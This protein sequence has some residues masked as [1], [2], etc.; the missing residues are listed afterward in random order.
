MIRKNL[1][2]WLRWGLVFHKVLHELKDQ[3]YVKRLGKDF[4][5]SVF[6]YI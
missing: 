2:I 1:T 5:N 3:I 4:V 6:V